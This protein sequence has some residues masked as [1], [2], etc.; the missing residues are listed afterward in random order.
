MRVL[1]NPRRQTRQTLIS[2][3]EFSCWRM[4]PII[5]AACRRVLLPRLAAPF[6]LPAT[7]GFA[8]PLR[9]LSSP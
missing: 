2:I 8:G 9:R 4:S 1:C 7:G 3:R 5:D 6:M